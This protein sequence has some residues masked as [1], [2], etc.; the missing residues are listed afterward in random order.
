[1][2]IYEKLLC[3]HNVRIQNL[4]FTLYLVARPCSD[5]ICFYTAVKR[6]RTGQWTIY[7]RQEACPYAEQFI[8]GHGLLV[9][10][11]I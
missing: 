4:P 7:F 8:S 6:P 5:I 3:F 11:C 1:M 9:N 10:K 2:Y